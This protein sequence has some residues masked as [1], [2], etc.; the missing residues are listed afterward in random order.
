[1][2]IKVCPD[3]A[4]VVAVVARSHSEAVASENSSGD[5]VVVVTVVEVGQRLS[6]ECALLVGG[7]KANYS[8]SVVVGVVEDIRL[9]FAVEVVVGTE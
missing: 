2:P 8:A 5:E 1:M 9:V 3:K 6:K 7:R 4:A